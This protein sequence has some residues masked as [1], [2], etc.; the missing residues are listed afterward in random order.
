MIAPLAR[1]MNPAG[2]FFRGDPVCDFIALVAQFEP[3][4][5][6]EKRNTQAAKPELG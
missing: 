6:H 5:W 3:G 1:G 4:G 2:R